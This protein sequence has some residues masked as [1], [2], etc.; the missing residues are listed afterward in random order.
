MGIV[1]K[2]WAKVTCAHGMLSVSVKFNISSTRQIV[3]PTD[4]QRYGEVG[5]DQ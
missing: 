5:G 1:H 2:D 3:A 4:P